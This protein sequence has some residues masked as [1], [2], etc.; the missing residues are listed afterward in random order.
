MVTTA[1]PTQSQAEP[2][3]PPSLLTDFDLYLFNEGTH[4]RVYEKLGAHPAV[5][6]DGTHGTLFA[7]WA[8]NAEAVSVIG[9]FNN[10]DWQ[11][12]PLHNRGNSGI[13]EGFVPGLGQG[14]LYKYSIKPKTSWIRIE[15]ADPYGFASELRP[16]TASAVWD[17]QQYQWQDGEWIQQRGERQSLQAPISIYEVHLGSWKRVPDTGGFLT[18]RDLAHQ[19]AEYC[20]RMGYTHVELL[21]VS[22]HPF[23]PSWGYQTVGYYAPTSRFGSPDDFKAFVDILH[24]AGIG[25]LLD[26]VPAHF[27]RDPHGLATFDGTALYEHSDPRLGEHP[28]WGTKIF[29]YGRHEVRSFLLSNA[30]FWVEQFHIDGLRVDAVASMLYLDYSRNAGEWIP[31]QYGGRENLEAISFLQRMN[32]VVHTECPGV[33][34]VA[35]ESTAW[36]QVTRPPYMGGLGFSLKWNMGWMH[37]TLQYISREPIHRRYHHHELTFSMLYAFHENF[38]LPLSHDEVVHGKGSLLNKIPGDAWQKFATLRLLYAY[39]FAHPGKKLLFQGSDFGQGDEWTEA[40]SIDWHL[41]QYPY[42]S[43]LQHCLADL[44]HLYRSDPALHQ[45]DFDWRGFD[46][47]ESHD[48]E[49]SVFAFMRK[50]EDPRDCVVVVSNFTP[51]PR[52]EYRVGVPFGGPWREVLNTDAETYGGG[53]IG[54]GGLIHA[55][56][57]PWAAQPHSVCLTL[58]PLGAIYLKPG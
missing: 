53:N 54:N 20:M 40:H 7:V 33:L 41:L 8:P 16:R 56:D 44:N 5:A 2:P 36:P 46:W 49:N 24:Q 57:E 4:V 37:D 13:W 12:T 43:G 10:W 55:L 17:H 14:T 52:Q 58:P 32:E 9:D 39:M 35:E 27:P 23:D 11:A 45:I 25:V 34:T 26:W 1:P 22:E 50:A 31:N 3:P 28:D 42:Q 51:V 19:L 38:V 48:N 47:L 18:Y 30:V 21:P 6:A 29:N 15:K